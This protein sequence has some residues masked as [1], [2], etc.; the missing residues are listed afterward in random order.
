MWVV[1]VIE[2]GNRIDENCLLK[3]NVDDVR[4]F[5]MYPFGERRWATPTRAF[6]GDGSMRRQDK[7]Q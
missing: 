2:L 6:Q 7:R 4:G 1:V 5:G 3:G